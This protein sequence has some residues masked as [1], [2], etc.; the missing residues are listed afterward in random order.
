[1]TSVE[2]IVVRG[3]EVFMTAPARWGFGRGRPGQLV[4]TSD[5]VAFLDE[6]EAGSFHFRIGQPRRVTHE[7]TGVVVE[8]GT[9]RI[10]FSGLTPRAADEFAA[11]LVSTLAERL[12]A[13]DPAMREELSRRAAR[14]K[15]RARSAQ[16]TVKHPLRKVGVGERLTAAGERLAPTRT[17]TRRT[18]WFFWWS[19]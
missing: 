5:R 16:R 8:I 12:Y 2:D 15:R 13:S 4:V 9:E 14:I 3:E 17:G 11:T 6:L 19:N 1:M 10:H 18:F 7:T